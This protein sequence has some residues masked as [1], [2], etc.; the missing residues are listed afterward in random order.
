[1]P[2]TGLLEKAKQLFHD[3]ERVPAPPA[4]YGLAFGTMLA[5]APNAKNVPP[6]YTFGLI[7]SI[8]YDEELQERYGPGFSCPVVVCAIRQLRR[9]TSFIPTPAEVLEACRQHR[10]KF[11]DLQWTVDVLMRVRQNAEELKAEFNRQFEEDFGPL[12]DY[13]PKTRPPG[14][15]PPDDDEPVPF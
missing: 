9:D 11:R 5:G 3:A 12:D 6:A 2:E 10:R 14:W 4:W 1:V 8:L 7:D 13:K 15:R